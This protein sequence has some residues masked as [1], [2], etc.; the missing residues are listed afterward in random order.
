MVVITCSSLK[1]KSLSRCATFFKSNL[2][3]PASE[4]GCLHDISFLGLSEEVF[5]KYEC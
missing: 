1:E 2:F 3:S 4:C 5:E